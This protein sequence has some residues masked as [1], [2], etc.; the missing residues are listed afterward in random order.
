MMKWFIR[1]RLAAFEKKLGYDFSY[2]RHVGSRLR[3]IRPL[4]Q[5]LR[6][7]HLGAAA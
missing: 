5:D 3:R 2:M 4:R 7:L 1:T 6:D